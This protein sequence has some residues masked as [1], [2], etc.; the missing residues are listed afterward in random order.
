M[1][2]TD[3]ALKKELWAAIYESRD[4]NGHD[5]APTSAVV[6]AVLPI[7]EAEVRAAKAEAILM[8]GFDVAVADLIADAGYAEYAEDEDGGVTWVSAP[9]GEVL[10][11]V[12]ICATEYET[13]DRT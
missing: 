5:R 1:T 3:E 8:D 12:R 6:T 7:M 10:H 4:L 2:T 13:G 11:I 9:L